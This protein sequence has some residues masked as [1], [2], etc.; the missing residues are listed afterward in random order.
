MVWYGDILNFTLIVLTKYKYMFSLFQALSVL[1][2]LGRRG[3]S[4]S[5]YQGWQ[6]MYSAVHVVLRK[7]WTQ[8]EALGKNTIFGLFVPFLGQNKLL[9]SLLRLNKNHKSHYKQH[10]EWKH[11][12]YPDYFSFSSKIMLG[13]FEKVISGVRKVDMFL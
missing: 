13:R 5:Y 1:F 7:V 8:W 3:A 4:W 12:K 2:W 6:K 11:L 9:E 10:V